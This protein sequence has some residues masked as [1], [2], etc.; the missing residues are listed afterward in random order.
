M[1][2]KLWKQSHYLPQQAQSMGGTSASHNLIEPE[3]GDDLQTPDPSAIPGLQMHGQQQQPG[4][5]PQQDAFGHPNQNVRARKFPYFVRKGMDGMLLHLQAAVPL[6]LQIEWGGLIQ[7]YYISQNRLHNNHCLFGLSKK[8]K[9]VKSLTPM[10]LQQGQQQGSPE[11]MWKP[12]KQQQQDQLQEQQQFQQQQQ[13]ELLPT[14][15]E[16]QLMQM[17]SLQNPKTR[18]NL[19]RRCSIS[20]ASGRV[21]V[22]EKPLM[23]QRAITRSTTS[24]VGALECP[25]ASFS[26]K[27][28]Y[29]ITNNLPRQAL[30]E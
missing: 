28:L 23:A 2:R 1:L 8:E 19:E 29:Y 21:L 16:I 7:Q 13:L 18:C 4:Q 20:M 14:S 30:T 6:K 5:L 27:S 12:K 11:T 24:R 25:P 3:R 15:S 9:K 17:S 10:M 26:D 22:S